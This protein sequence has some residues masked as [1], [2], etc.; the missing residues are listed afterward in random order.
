[1]KL[2]FLAFFLTLP[3]FGLPIINKSGSSF[4]ATLL[5]VINKGGGR[6][7]IK[8]IRNSDRRIFLLNL[9]DLSKECLVY[10]I[11]DLHR[12]K[13]DLVK[14][15]EKKKEIVG[16]I[17]VKDPIKPPLALPNQP[18]FP[19]T[20]IV[21]I[22]SDV[23]RWDR[24]T[25]RI[26]G[27]LHYRSSSSEE[28]S[29]NQGDDVSIDVSYKDL[30]RRDKENILKLK[31]FSDKKIQVFGKLIMSSFYSNSLTLHARRVEF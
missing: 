3:S 15:V 19:G 22:L 2:L 26:N 8:V 29:I 1:M 25:V 12:N 5:D 16:N 30:P 10:L 17:E 6:V 14:D 20:Q 4:E 13:S 7:D 11:V 21:E 28:F 27:L 9:E 31:N 18:D 23:K 24:K